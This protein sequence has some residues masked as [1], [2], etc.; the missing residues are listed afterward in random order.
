MSFL[1]PAF[2]GRSPAKD[3]G[4]PRRRESDKPP[5]RARIRRMYERP[6]AFTN[7]LPW[8][9]Y[10]EESK[11]FLLDDGKS[12]G[13]LFEAQVAGVEARPGAFM[14]ELRDK[15]QAALNESIPEDHE[16]PW[17]V[18]FYVQDEPSLGQLAGDIERYA[19]PRAR[20]TPYN[21]A[22]MNVIR[23]HLE[24]IQRPQ[25]L[26]HDENVTG[27]PWRGVRRRVRLALY[28]RVTGLGLGLL[29]PELAVNEVAE[30]LAVS[31]MS[32]GVRLKRLEGRDLYEWM[33]RWLNPNPL[34]TSGDTEAALAQT[35]WPESEAERPFGH[36]FS[37]MLMLGLPHSDQENGLWWFDGLPHRAITIQ[38]LRRIPEIG[39]LTAERRIGDHIYSVFD[40]MPEGTVMAM[41]VVVLAQDQVK[42]HLHHIRRR[43]V[44]DSAEAELAAE[45]ADKALKEL[46]RGNKLYQLQTA[47][48]LRGRDLHD[49]QGR[50]RQA[51]SLLIASG[52]QPIV[53]RQDL[54][55]LDSYIKNLPMAYDH[56]FDEKHA[57]RSRLLF[58][59]HAANLAPLYGRSTGSGHPGMLFF[60]RGGEP[61]MFD[62]LNLKD[63]KKN[64][65]TLIIGPTGAGK[66]ATLVYLMMHMMAMHRPRL[67]VIEA[68][69]S[70][71]LL[72]RWFKKQGLSVNRVQF[73]PNAD[74][75]VP[76]FAHGVKLLDGRYHLDL[77]LDS[78]TDLDDDPTND[79]DDEDEDLSERDLLGEMEIAARTMITGGDPR[80]EERLR[81]A[82][83]LLI[84]KAL[85]QAAR[86]VKRVGRRQVLTEDVVRA[87]RTLEGLEE[88]R[89]KRAG[90]MADAMEM[91][92]TGLA[93]NFFNREG[94]PWPEV[95]A[96]FVD[97]GILARDGYEDQLT[98]AYM[99]LINHIH[100][101]IERYQH[102]PRPTLVLTDECHLIM[103]N[104]LLA[105]YIVK[106]VK[107]WR[108]LG[109]WY[110]VATQNLQDFPD[111][112]ARLL[113]MIEWWLCLVMPKDEVDQIAR[114]K[115]LSE[116]QRALLLAARKQPPLYT[117]GVALSDEMALLF[118]NVPP[119]L[120][121]ALAMTEK[122]EKARRAELMEKFGIDELAAAEKVAE[123]LDRIRGGE[124]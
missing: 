95:D 90:E 73:S 110:W 117:E 52:L 9:D 1:P 78:P 87:L 106:I 118:R 116:E 18:Q 20:G 39:A 27:A 15:I 99:G 6:S 17:I 8:L 40:R 82:D 77:D 103:V 113:N 35:P 53:D 96:T 58:S 72:A 124:K 109:A 101:L 11:T 94:T 29:T 24:S 64:A 111:S 69:D 63:R 5:T 61:V 34:L 42:N 85:I 107:M 57:R 123:E 91:F 7:L 105:P 66:S 74:I 45:D 22:W 112:T 104:P 2:L 37:E 13:A 88:S 81:R 83:R 48:Y 4:I 120:S 65:H 98:V 84:R 36:D 108:K 41:T 76:P 121:L 10:D 14:V 43:A 16:S 62:P 38:A 68:G 119:A 44:G 25:G 51:A 97:L 21:Q 3:K 56:Q 75:A 100:G 60:N 93:G 26:F 19:T 32:A 89:R 79:Y 80:E 55:P 70:F 115:A 67:F 46:A 54:I 28:R 49:I 33:F 59:R 71:G 12:V 50:M 86:E 23:R 122:E 30:K 114:F 31:L 47:F 102:D 92:C